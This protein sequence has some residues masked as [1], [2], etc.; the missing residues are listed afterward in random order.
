MVFS[1][2]MKN[3]SSIRCATVDSESYSIMAE[4]P[5]MVC[6]MRKIS[7]TSFCVNVSACSA[8]STMLSSCSSSVFVSYR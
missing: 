7:F 4:A 5:L 3:I 8:A 1:R 6:M 2:M